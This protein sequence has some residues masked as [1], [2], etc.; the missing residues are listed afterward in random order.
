MVNRVGHAGHQI[1]NRW[2]LPD[3]AKV[4]DLHKLV[5]R[6]LFEPAHISLEI[7]SRQKLCARPVQMRAGSLDSGGSRPCP[8]GRLQSPC[9]LTGVPPSARAARPHAAETWP[10]RVA[11]V[12]YSFFGPFGTRAKARDYIWGSMCRRECSRGL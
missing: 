7:D 10:V 11:L 9:A 8:A 6:H 3:A 5:G 12:V 1:G 2:K 4:D